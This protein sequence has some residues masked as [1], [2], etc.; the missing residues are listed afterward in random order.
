MISW[1]NYDQTSTSLV[2]VALDVGAMMVTD[3]ETG[4]DVPCLMTEYVT[5]NAWSLAISAGKL[6]VKTAPDFARNT[7]TGN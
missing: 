2:W 4:V 6:Y 7:L 5:V 1:I 3:K